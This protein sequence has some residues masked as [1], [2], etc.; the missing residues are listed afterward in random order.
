M[1]RVLITGATGFVGVNLARRVLRD[2]HEIHLLVRRSRQSWRLDE[3]AADVRLH[4]ADLEDR[5]AVRRA[6][7]EVKPDWVFH[8]AAY[9]AY[10][11]QTD[12]ERMGATNLTG[13]VTLLDACR[14]IGV[15]AFV[16]TGSSSEY[17]YKDHPASEDELLQP[18]SHYAITKAAATHY[19]QFVAR[20]TGLNAVT[21][22]LYSVYG[23]YEEPARFIP[24]LIVH[25]LRG[26]LPPL[27]SPAT[28]RDFVYVDD[29]VDAMLRVAAAPPLPRGTVLNVCT[30]AQTTLASAVAIAR[31]LMSIPASPVWSSMSAR[32]WDT[33]VW[34]GSPS[35]AERELGWRARFDFETGLRHTI[36]WFRDNPERLAFYAARIRSARTHACRVETFLDTSSRS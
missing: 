5:E 10:P 9:G 29:A 27:V 26:Q 35:A 22:R 21:V 2:G 7:S 18:N 32:A 3:I 17:G 23:P 28:A 4:E 8:L 30:G 1:K 34:V 36:A 24:T 13:S 31:Q 19:G 16:Q 12:F 14:E 6:V 15:E 25:G 33:D 20:S 11:T